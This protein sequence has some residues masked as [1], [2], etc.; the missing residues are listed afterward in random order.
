MRTKRGGEVNC[1]S[2]FL[3]TLSHACGVGCACSGVGM[4]DR[5]R[6]S[7]ANS[8]SEGVQLPLVS[9]FMYCDSPT[10]LVLFCVLV[11]LCVEGGIVGEVVLWL[12][13]RCW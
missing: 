12:L 13:G 9:I 10:V 11:L 5:P 4:N 2:L 3:K 6:A 1:I 8:D 7:S